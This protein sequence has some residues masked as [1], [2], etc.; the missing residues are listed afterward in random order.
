MFSA[1]QSTSAESHRVKLQA[2]EH[3]SQLANPHTSGN[4]AGHRTNCKRDLGW[5]GKELGVSSYKH[6]NS[7]GTLSGL[8]LCTDCSVILFVH[9]LWLMDV[10]AIWNDLPPK[11]V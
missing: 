10:F 1:N 11:N 6:F 3:W 2:A 7:T 4:T 8:R 5:A 9:L